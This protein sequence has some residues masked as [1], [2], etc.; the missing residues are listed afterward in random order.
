MNEARRFLRY[1]APGLAG[2]IE[3]VFLI[4]IS[5]PARV[6]PGRDNSSVPSTF[7][8]T[9]IGAGLAALLGA[10]LA[11]LVVS[12]GLGFVLSTVHHAAYVWVRGLCIDHRGVLT[13]A[14]KKGKLKVYPESSELSR[15]EA[16]RILAAFWH[17]RLGESPRLRSANPRVDTL[18][19]I[20]HGAGTG[21]YGA[22]FAF[23]CWLL[24]ERHWGDPIWA[25]WGTCTVAIV[26][27][28]M[29]ALAFLGPLRHAEGV[30]NAIAANE[31]GAL[32]DGPYVYGRHLEPTVPE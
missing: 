13:W 30:I 8:G 18:T 17:E 4:F 28:A 1:V 21:F 27:L 19:D 11:A 3:C 5:H 20:V 6:L 7:L 22:A 24:V 26:L 23:A 10:A 32:E 12:G 2:I 9:N 14:I 25:H 29:H 31:L 16:W 15:R